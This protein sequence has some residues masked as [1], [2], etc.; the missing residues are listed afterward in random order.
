MSLFGGSTSLFDSSKK[1]ESGGLFQPASKDP[2]T[3]QPVESKDAS[4][5]TSLFDKPAGGSLF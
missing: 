1:V 3:E 2:K 5:G 4:K